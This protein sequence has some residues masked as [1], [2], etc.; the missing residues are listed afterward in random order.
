MDNKYDK[1]LTIMQVTIE[2]NRQESDEKI[3]ISHK[4]SKQ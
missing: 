1:Q 2:P 3:K 4:T